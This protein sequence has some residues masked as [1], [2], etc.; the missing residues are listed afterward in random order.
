MYKLSDF[1]YTLPQGLI[2]QYPSAQRDACRLMVL[3]RSNG[4]IEHAGFRDIIDFFKKGDL[5]VFNDTKVLPAR[6]LG[7]RVTGGKVEVFLLRPKSSSPKEK[8]YHALIKPLGRL[9]VGEKIFF[10]RGFSCVLADAKEKLVEFDGDDPLDCMRKVGSI[11]L[12]PY[13]KRDPQECDRIRYQTVFAEKE[14]AVAAPTAGLHF[15]KELLRNLRDKGVKTAFL[16][17]HVNY[18]TFSPLRT[19][20]IRGHKMSPEYYEIPSATLESVIE[21]KRNKGRVFAV[22]TTVCKALEE[23][24]RHRRKNAPVDK[25]SGSSDLFIYPPFSFKAVDVLVTNFHLPRTSLLLLVSAFAGRDLIL[26]AYAQAV[27]SGYRFYS[28]GDAML[29][30]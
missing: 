11:P 14:G 29:I 28:Y 15:T 5:V 6:L 27:E 16:T 22:G 2:A 17:L 7:K 26:K 19:D 30:V 4:S 24:L 23:G 9:K 1:D 3:D 18:A 12:P 20:D 21:T 13:I 10:D 8:R 25:I